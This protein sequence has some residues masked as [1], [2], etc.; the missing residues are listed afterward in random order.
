MIPFT[1]RVD[2]RKLLDN[3]ITFVG[4]LTFSTSKSSQVLFVHNYGANKR[5][6]P[7]E[8]THIVLSIGASTS[9]G[10]CFGQTFNSG[11]SNYDDY[12]TTIAYSSATLIPFNRNLARNGSALKSLA[13]G[14]SFY[15]TG[16][17]QSTVTSTVVRVIVSCVLI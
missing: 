8:I 16:G 12:V 4:D 7:Y 13:Y 11:T 10:C 9:F 3:H 2:A 6:I 14:T 1:N 5:L 15:C 17:F